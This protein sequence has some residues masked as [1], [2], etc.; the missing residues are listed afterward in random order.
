M[1]S[2][3][4]G[5]DVY[6]DARGKSVLREEVFKEPDGSLGFGRRKNIERF[7]SVGILEGVILEDI[8]ECHSSGSVEICRTVDLGRE[9]LLDAQ[10]AYAVGDVRSP[11]ENAVP[12]YN[13]IVR[14]EK[15]LVYI[16]E[17]FLQLGR[18]HFYII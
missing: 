7:L 5:Q 9:F 16:E 4:L 13:D 15:S 6:L 14:I 11:G 2:W 12:V 17:V 1:S 8:S 18:V 10:S 3:H